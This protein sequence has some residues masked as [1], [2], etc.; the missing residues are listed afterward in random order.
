MARG[1]SQFDPGG[2]I[3]FRRIR[4]L[5]VGGPVLSGKPAGQD[6]DGNDHYQHERE[7]RDDDKPL[8]FADRTLGIEQENIAAAAQEGHGA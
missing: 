3:P 2:I 6:K 8:A 7:G 4:C 1:T 5:G